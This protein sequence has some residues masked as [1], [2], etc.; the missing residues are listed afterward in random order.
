MKFLLLPAAFALWLFSTIDAQAQASLETATQERVNIRAGDLT[1]GA[2]LYLP[3][4]EHPPLPVIVTG[5]G[6]A[7]STRDDVGFYTNLALRLGYAVLSYDKRGTGDSGGQYRPFSVEHSLA[8][9]QTLASDH[10]EATRWVASHPS[11]DRTRI[12]YLGGS[13]AGWIMPLAAHLLKGEINIQFVVIGEGT[14]L[15]AEA[16]AIHGDFLTARYE[17]NDTLTRFD[18]AE[19]DRLLSDFEPVRGFDPTSFLEDYA[20]PTLWIFGLNDPVIPIQPSIDRLA[21]LIARGHYHHSIEVL[22][23]SDHN[24]TNTATGERYD[25][26]DII[27]PWIDT[28]D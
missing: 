20:T 6:S 18:I 13:Q 1:L 14:P 16:E 2:T 21:G 15:S 7:P 3:P 12:G 9:F 11:I 4:G 28:L 23:F 10:A 8:D 17:A 5:H 19:A 26:A 27:R 24:F 25:L 22:P